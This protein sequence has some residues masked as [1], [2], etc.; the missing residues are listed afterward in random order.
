MQAGTTVAL[1]IASAVEDGGTVASGPSSSPV[2]MLLKATAGAKQ[3]G[4]ATAEGPPRELGP[5]PASSFAFHATV[6][7]PHVQ[8]ERARARKQY[9]GDA[10]SG[11]SSPSDPGPARDARPG[12]SEEL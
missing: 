2:Q 1:E 4:H 8:E 5:L 3:A 7:A 9:E 10:P 6:A 12:R 11:D